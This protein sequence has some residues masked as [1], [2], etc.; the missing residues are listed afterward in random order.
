LSISIASGS[1]VCKTKRSVKGITIVNNPQPDFQHA[2]EAITAAP[3]LPSFPA[4]NMA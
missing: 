3:I 1:I 2:L 4:I